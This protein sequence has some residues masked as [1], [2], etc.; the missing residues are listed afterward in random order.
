MNFL[1]IG[2][3]AINAISIPVLSRDDVAAQVCMMP[4]NLVDAACCAAKGVRA[5]LCCR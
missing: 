4:F 3:R 5:N 1:L 2:S